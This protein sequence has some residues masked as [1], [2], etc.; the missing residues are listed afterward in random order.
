MELHTTVHALEPDQA[1]RMVFMTGGAFT[2]GAASFLDGVANERI[3]K[4]LPGSAE[5]RALIRKYVDAK[6]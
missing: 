5:L 6:F 4:L 2:M 3:M 1:R